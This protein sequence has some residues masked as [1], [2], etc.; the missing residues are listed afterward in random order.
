MRFLNQRAKPTAFLVFLML[1]A[2]P[3]SAGADDKFD[4][5]KQ[6]L[7]EQERTVTE[8]KAAL[9]KVQEEQ[10]ATKAAL[11]Q[12]SQEKAGTINP[13]AVGSVIEA[14]ERETSSKFLI[15]GYGAADFIAKQGA[16]STFAVALSPA[17]HFSLTDD[18]HANAE[19]EITQNEE[20]A[21]ETELEYAELDY[22]LANNIEIAA[23]KMLLPLNVFG[24]RLHPQW[25]NKLPSLP[26]LYG[27]HDSGSANP[28]ILPILT[29]IGLQL[30]GG[31]ETGNES[32]VNYALYVVNG[33]RAEV[34]EE[35]SND[36]AGDDEEITRNVELVFGENA[37]DNNGNKSVGGRI[38]V[39]PIS[40]AEIGWSGLGGKYL[41]D[42]TF[43]VWGADGEFRAS[44]FELRAEYLKL[45]AG[46]DGGEDIRRDGF[47]VQ[48]SY[49]LGKLEL[50]SDLPQYFS[51]LEFVSRFGHAQ[52]TEGTLR[53]TALGIVYWLTESAPLKCAYE[54]N[55]G[56]EEIRSDRFLAQL[57]Y[58]F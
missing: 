48:G 29:D 12:L 28:G 33:P 10:K 15:T 53:Q 41:D 6:A 39:I 27:E 44:G 52:T 20:E 35:G 1:F 11:E 23:G 16:P 54:I 9:G 32:M 58:G 38:G 22:F 36:T 43:F 42:D 56:A 7:A 47:Y 24:E 25:I 57:A 2:L 19:L 8:L 49:R 46:V 21:T 4:E 34:E 18:L 50:L 13:D 37:Q 51:K 5:L 14:Y 45:G 55:D 31:V 17:L 30:R 3:G 40:G 26:P